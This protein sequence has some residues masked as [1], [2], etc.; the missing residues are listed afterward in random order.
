MAIRAGGRGGGTL[1]GGK[2][3]SDA[4]DLLCILNTVK[5]VLTY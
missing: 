3:M 5:L 1:S 2:N 4:Q